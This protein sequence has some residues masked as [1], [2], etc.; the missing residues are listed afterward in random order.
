MELAGVNHSVVYA[1]SGVYV[2]LVRQ[3]YDYTCGPAS[4]A[5]CL[6]YW[7]VW[8]GSEPQLY[9]LCQTTWQEG[10]TWRGLVKGARRMGLMARVERKMTTKRL[11]QLVRQGKT[12]ILSIQSNNGDNDMNMGHTW[13][14]GHYVVLV[15]IRGRMV[16]VMDPEYAGSYRTMTVE[17][18]L[19]CWHDWNGGRKE[20]RGG[21]VLWGRR[22]SRA[23][24][25]VRV[26]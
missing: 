3:A 4:L 15:S 7:G 8:S 14:N 26:G 16:T 17:E 18:L 1:P 9:S 5:S 25:P 20:F 2:P 24:R 10:T 13:E 22:V 11:R 21:I 6:Y 12:I 23:I 19:G